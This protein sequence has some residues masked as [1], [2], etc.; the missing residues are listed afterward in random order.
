MARFTRPMRYELFQASVSKQWH[1][2]YS[3]FVNGT[4]TAPQ[5]VAGPYRQFLAGDGTASG[6]QF[7]YFDSTGTRLTNIA[8]KRGVSRLDVYMRAAHG[9][10]AITERQGALMT[11]ST[12]FR[13]GLR[14]YK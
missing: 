13:I 8:Q 5:A 2:G 9:T 6:L 3:E 14:N 11:D 7:R 4:W 12:L 1:L 10:S